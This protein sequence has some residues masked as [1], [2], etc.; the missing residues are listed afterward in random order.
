MVIC[1]SGRETAPDFL[2]FRHGDRAMRDS[3]AIL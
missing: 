1:D 3:D 2:L